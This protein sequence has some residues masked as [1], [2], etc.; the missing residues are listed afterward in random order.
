[1]SVH[2]QLFE[3][4]CKQDKQIILNSQI[5]LLEALKH[6]NAYA[7]L[8]AKE[9]ALKLALRSK[10][11]QISQDIK[12]IHENFPAIRR[13]QLTEKKIPVKDNRLEYE[14]KEIQDKLRKLT[15]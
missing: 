11:N 15:N 9:L 8:R 7:K 4:E 6:Q 10:L 2:I 12:L 3:E 1:M 5:N 13:F 14:L